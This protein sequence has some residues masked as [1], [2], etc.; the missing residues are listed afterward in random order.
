MRLVKYGYNLKSSIACAVIFFG[1]GILFC[2]VEIDMF[3]MGGLYIVLGPLMLV[4]I[5][6][7][8][9][10]AGMAL[11]S[12]RRRFIEIQLQDGLQILVGVLGY[13]LVV[14]IAAIK[15]Y[16]GHSTLELSKVYGQMV[17]YTGIMTGVLLVYMGIVYKYF[18]VSL[19]LFMGG[20]SFVY[21][22]LWGEMI[23]ITH[24]VNMI[25]G[26]LLGLLFVL[27]GEV[28]S[29]VM[30]RILYKKP[31]NKYAMGMALRKQM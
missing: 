20:F 23:K 24:S 1:V 27:I 16:Q 28:L 19:I 6:Y 7:T 9:L 22:G 11:S 10:M 13:L 31:L 25:S 18:L 12:P 5:I 14:L 17:L 2:V 8:G 29:A 21:T 15:V 3:A 30:R 4:Q 26:T